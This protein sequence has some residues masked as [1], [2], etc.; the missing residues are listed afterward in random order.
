MPASLC[1][2]A[3]SDKNAQDLAR[4]IIREIHAD[5][6]V[7]SEEST[8]PGVFIHV[9]KISTFISYMYVTRRRTLRYARVGI[10]KELTDLWTDIIVCVTI[11]RIEELMCEDRDI[12]STA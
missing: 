12:R 6:A 5:E 1:E 7:Y 2:T 8:Q 10:I 3:I 9:I 11:C 4:I